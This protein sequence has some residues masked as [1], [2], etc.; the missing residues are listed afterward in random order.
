MC[1]ASRSFQYKPTSLSLEHPT[2]LHLSAC[3]SIKLDWVNN[4][5]CAVG[6]DLALVDG[7][8]TPIVIVFAWMAGASLALGFRGKVN[9]FTPA[10][11]AMMRSNAVIYGYRY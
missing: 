6:V 3:S 1:V 2:S 11:G 5:H 10:L 7:W 8:A 9:S 4:E